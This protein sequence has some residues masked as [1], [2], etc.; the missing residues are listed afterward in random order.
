MQ[1][2]LHSRHNRPN[3]AAVES[4][5]GVAEPVILADIAPGTAQPVLRFFGIISAIGGGNK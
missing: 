3:A 1:A 5:P 4:V 2:F